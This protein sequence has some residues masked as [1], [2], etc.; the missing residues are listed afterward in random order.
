M[1]N[2][3]IGIVILAS[4]ILFSCSK[5]LDITP[6]DNITDEQIKAILASGDEDK[7]NMVMESMA[8][9]MQDLFNSGA[10]TG[11]A[12]SD[13][14]YSTRQGLNV[15][16]NLEGNDIVFGNKNLSIFGSDEYY[17]RDFISTGVDKNRYYWHW[18]WTIITTA[19]KMLNYLDEETVGSSLI[20]KEFKARG[21]AARAFGYS[22]LMENY[23]DSYLQ[24]GKDKLGVMLYD[25]YSPT[26]DYKARASSP[27]TYDFIKNDL[28]TAISLF[29]E[30]DKGYT[31]EILTDIDLSVANFLLAR[32][33]L[34][35]GDWSTSISAC[36]NILN[37]YPTLMGEDVYGGTKNVSTDLVPEIRP[38]TN[39]FL[40]N[41]VNPEV[42]LGWPVGQAL[43]I[44]NSWMN[45]FGEGNGGLGAGFARI[46]NRLYDNID[47]N[48]YRKSCF[49]AS[50]FGDY[51]YP[52][53]GAVQYIPAYTNLKFAATHG[54]GLDDKKEVGSVTCYYMRSSEALLMKAEAQ[55]QLGSEENAKETLDVLLAARTKEGETNL[56]CDTY[57]SMAG[58][59]ALEMVQLQTRIELWGETGS[60]F[61]NNKR[62]GIAV[63][64]TNS[65]NHIDKGTY[66]V[67]D[68]TLQIPEEEILYN[69]LCE[70]N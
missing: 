34:I 43:T 65:D 48:D 44:H 12:G 1:K 68:M 57:S 41:D 70:Q 30:A 59:T 69:P 23:Q 36:D 39:G 3:I 24:G 20:L 66:R 42:I 47:T 8:N 11:A 51:A 45:P 14:R 9:A 52:T 6:P 58:M 29:N 62:W 53:T 50:D 26:Q 33:C 15:M 38:E 13:P 61:F 7:I 35:T 5:E 25:Y 63:D 54:I 60:E 17:L 37:N 56:T 49:M 16:R 18:S 46:D 2:Y 4:M 67:V 22:Y 64:R 28:Q 10:A 32:V 31:T 55:A 40:F 19:N 27:E 21:L